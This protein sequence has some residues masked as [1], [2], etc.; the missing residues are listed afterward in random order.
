M[1]QGAYKLSL[2][3]YESSIHYPSNNEAV[4]IG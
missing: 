2:S 3:P 1:L 4:D